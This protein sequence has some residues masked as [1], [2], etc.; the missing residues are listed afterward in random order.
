MLA[1]RW[2]VHYNTVRPH[3]SLGYRPSF[4]VRNPA[5]VQAVVAQPAVE[6]FV[7]SWQTG[8]RSTTASGPTARWTTVHHREF[9]TRLR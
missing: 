5:G 6:A 3:S 2:R 8:S 9:K 1:E 7:R 4:S